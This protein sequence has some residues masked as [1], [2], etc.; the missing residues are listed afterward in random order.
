MTVQVVIPEMNKDTILLTVDDAKKLAKID[1]YNNY[2]VINIVNIG[3][4]GS[5]ISE[6]TFDEILQDAERIE[7][8]GE[9]A[10]QLGHGIALINNNECVFVKH[11]PDKMAEYGVIEDET[12]S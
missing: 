8:A 10:M 6:A 1:E 3:F 9:N 11:D 7:I 5:N 12:D 4:I 2:H